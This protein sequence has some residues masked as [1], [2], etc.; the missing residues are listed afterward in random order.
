MKMIARA[1]ALREAGVIILMYDSTLRHIDCDID[2]RELSE[3]DIWLW[4]DY[5]LGVERGSDK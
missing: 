3:S 4:K 2:L 1:S 5:L